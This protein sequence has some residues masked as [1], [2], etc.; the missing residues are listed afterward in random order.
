MKL[1]SYQKRK[2][3]CRNISFLN[4]NFNFSV[5][6]INF[7]LCVKCGIIQYSKPYLSRF[8]KKLKH[9]ASEKI[10]FKWLC[11]YILFNYIIWFAICWYLKEVKWIHSL[12]YK[13][14]KVWIQ[15]KW[16]SV[17]EAK[18]A[19]HILFRLIDWLESLCELKKYKRF[20][21]EK[22]SRH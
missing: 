3:H 18:Y 5:E 6:W 15:T 2:T 21:Q 11:I 19:Q 4:I 12:N 20:F 13:W 8:I 7:I 9:H 16:E 17:D 10:I 22:F 1:V 14:N